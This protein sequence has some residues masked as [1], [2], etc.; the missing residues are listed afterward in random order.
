[1]CR[2]RSSG[3]WKPAEHDR[4]LRRRP[5]LPEAIRSDGESPARLPAV[6]AYAQLGV[7]TEFHW[8]P[9][10]VFSRPAPCFTQSASLR[11]WDSE[12]RRRLETRAFVRAGRPPRPR[13]GRPR[14]S[15]PDGQGR[16]PPAAR[17][18]SSA[19]R[20][21]DRCIDAYL[22]GDRTRLAIKNRPEGPAGQPS[23]LDGRKSTASETSGSLDRVG[24]V[25][26]KLDA[27]S[28]TV[29]TTRSARTA[30]WVIST[31]RPKSGTSRVRQVVAGQ[32]KV[33]AGVS[34][35][36]VK[37]A[38]RPR[39]K[40][41][42]IARRAAG[43]RPD[44]PMRMPASHHG[45]FSPNSCADPLR[46]RI[47]GDYFSLARKWNVPVDDFFKDVRPLVAGHR[48]L[49]YLE[50]LALPP[51]RAPT[52]SRNWPNDSTSPR[53]SPPNVT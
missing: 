51:Q 35:N 28:V 24:A 14:R 41:K 43:A 13:S 1:M 53:L 5:A 21:C 2:P 23:D 7:L 4:G 16:H 6:R 20:R 11:G 25:N 8:H 33:V 9:A 32:A 3:S 37:N 34:P 45:V 50:N 46:P 17:A 31:W 42:L 30:I 44:G 49:P 52:R 29:P 15:D 26:S 27:D 40:T 47:S 39:T 19:A 48:F 10:Y 36:P 38:S 18:A 12:T 22:K